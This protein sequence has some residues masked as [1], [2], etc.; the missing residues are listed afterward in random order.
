MSDGFSEFNKGQ[1]P[2][3]GD[4]ISKP[5]PGGPSGHSLWGGVRA[6]YSIYQPLA[7]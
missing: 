5:L 1:F 2:L 7:C 3:H 6:G 4:V